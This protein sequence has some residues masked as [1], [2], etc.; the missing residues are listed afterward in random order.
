MKV[1]R[2]PL[3]ATLVGVLCLAISGIAF[4]QDPAPGGP[5]PKI[6]I[7][8]GTGSATN[9]FVEITVSVN[10]E[11]GELTGGHGNINTGPA[12]GHER[13][14]I[15]APAGGCEAAV[16][17]PPP[18]PDGNGPDGP[19]PFGPGPGPDGEPP[20]GGPPLGEEE[21]V[22]PPEEVVTEVVTTPAPPAA[23]GAVLAAEEAA[24]PSELAVTGLELWHLALLSGL[25]IL[26]G[27]GLRRAVATRA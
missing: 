6:T 8:H 18:G 19:G 4:G 25:T 23:E 7:C 26:G 11:T 1:G 3:L 20:T 5:D 15:P 13:D 17:P 27:F 22:E 2:I 24:E 10:A 16:V 14:I 9:P 12:P 21:V